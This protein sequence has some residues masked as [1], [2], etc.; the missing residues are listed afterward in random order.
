[1]YMSAQRFVFL[2]TLPSIA[3]SAKWNPLGARSTV[4]ESPSCPCLTSASA[5]QPAKNMLA[6]M[7]VKNVATG[8]SSEYGL[9]GCK[10]YDADVDHG[11]GSDAV[12]CAGSTTG[13]CLKNWCYV[14]PAICPVDKR[15]CT[16]KW[17]YNTTQQCRVGDPED[18]YCRSVPS[19][20]E[21]A[22][23]ALMGVRS[24]SETCGEIDATSLA[25]IWPEIVGS[26]LHTGWLQ[27]HPWNFRTKNATYPKTGYR[28]GILKA[29][30][31]KVLGPAGIS[32]KYAEPAV[33]AIA[34]WNFWLDAGYN[35]TWSSCV[36]DLAVGRL[37]FC[38]AD[39]W[40][41]A[42]RLKQCNFLPSLYSDSV[43]LVEDSLAEESLWE[44]L[45]KPFLP[46]AYDLWGFVLISLAVMGVLIAWVETG[47]NPD[48]YPDERCPMCFCKGVFQGVNSYLASGYYFQVYPRT[49]P[50]MCYSLGLGLFV[51]LSLSTY[52]A[53]LA[54]FLIL[55]KVKEGVN[56]LEDAVKT[57]A[58]ICISSVYLGEI[59]AKVPA[60]LRGSPPPAIGRSWR[61]C[62]RELHQATADGKSMYGVISSSELDLAYRGS[63][64]TRDCKG[65][66]EAKKAGYD[67]KTLCPADA[68]GNLNPKRDCFIKKV[69]DGAILHS[70]EV[71]C[72]STHAAHHPMSFAF[73]TAK[74]QGAWSKTNEEFSWA[75]T[76]I[77]ENCPVVVGDEMSQMAMMDMLGT[78]VASMLFVMA[79]WGMMTLRIRIVRRVV[80]AILSRCALLIPKAV[81][82]GMSGLSVKA[83]RLSKQFS[84]NKGV[85]EVVVEKDF[86][87][88]TQGETPGQSKL[89]THLEQKE[90]IE[91]SETRLD[92]ALG[93]A[94]ALV[95]TKLLN[96][97]T[98]ML[99]K[100]SGMEE[101]IS[102]TVQENV[103]VPAYPP[104]AKMVDVLTQLKEERRE[105]E[106]SW[107]KIVK[108]RV[109]NEQERARIDAHRDILLA[110]D[111]NPNSISLGSM[112]QQ[113]L[114]ACLQSEFRDA[115]AIPSQLER[116]MLDGQWSRL[117]KEREQLGADLKQVQDLESECAG[118]WEEA[119][120]F[121]LR[122]KLVVVKASSPRAK[123]SSPRNTYAM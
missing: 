105:V 107:Q 11:K 63:L 33:T 56:S 94:G 90:V 19:R 43:F 52:T 32:L 99:G 117:R 68:E 23:L 10:G 71:A 57:G 104:A 62:V 66:G 36:W 61:E 40:I 83:V 9:Q 45:Q 58:S 112:Q 5:S 85:D 78:S 34:R 54:S 110:V 64:I 111:S 96:K 93:N 109:T 72:A 27:S 30:W 26:T 100:P 106:D 4:K 8:F 31:D 89:H 103:E 102:A 73:A 120:K 35:S 46:F 42:G 86:L 116:T 75:R 79:G 108:L 44:I 87:N 113:I 92:E 84:R 29:Y 81:M 25:A 13:K 115:N 6:A 55:K 47:H 20:S 21:S 119:K 48:D 60:V 37:D 24:S 80:R 70:L 41:T 39:F 118:M 50:G 82:D 3:Q 16:A 122:T 22:G 123:G 53:N 1:M 67:G 101:A 97:V 91:A 17:C 98:Q 88:L 59:A 12:K 15:K 2:L 18:K 69:G 114:S 121:T 77:P 65:V 49:I 51:L 7:R 74:V 95:N 28:D 76:V 38:M 14:D